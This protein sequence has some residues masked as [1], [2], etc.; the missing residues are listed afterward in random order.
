MKYPIFFGN[1]IKNIEDS[2]EKM[3]KGGKLYITH[4]F[5]KGLPHLGGQEGE[6]EIVTS[7][8]EGLL[9]GVENRLSKYLEQKLIS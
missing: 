8:L 9:H 5:P 7:E 4:K 2:V 1:G 6:L 3:R